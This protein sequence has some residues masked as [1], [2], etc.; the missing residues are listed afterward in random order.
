MPWREIWGEH[1]DGTIT[2]MAD[3][4]KP[5]LEAI[6]KLIPLNSLAP[7]LRK[8]LLRKA[9]IVRYEEGKIIF[10][11]GNKDHFSFYLLDGTVKMEAKGQVRSTLTPKSEA[12]K[13]P[14]A[15]LQPRRFTAKAASKVT[16]LLINRHLV[17]KMIVLQEKE[18]SEQTLAEQG[19]SVEVLSAD[20]ESSQEEGDWMARMLQSELFSKIPTANIYKLFEVMD[21]IDAKAKQ[22]IIKQGDEGDSYF[23]IQSGRCAVV[24]QTSKNT[25]PKQLA[26]LGPGD[27]FGEE[28]LVSKGARN[29]SVVM[30]TN[31]TLMKLSKKNFEDLI[32]KT[33]LESV[34]H[35]VA[36][37]LI[38]EKGAK[39]LDVRFPSEV[40]DNPLEGSLNIPF[41]TLRKNFSK[42]DRSK[43]YI[44]C[45]DTGERSASAAFLLVKNGFSAC[46][47]SGGLQSVE[48]ES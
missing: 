28:A 32:R 7:K 29:A 12:A 21:P 24:Q 43:Q 16:M 9:S 27:S 30:L 26:T 13:Y 4:P 19:T 20:G 31:G 10:K 3:N 23:V 47:L 5:S 45:C 25:P 34:S 39:W 1:L 36:T 17:D 11:E 44:A 2:E 42:L 35:K 33:A 6:N 41:Y 46:F 14:V 38:E 37:K 8:D 18:Q 22:A 15:Q 48:Q 40:S